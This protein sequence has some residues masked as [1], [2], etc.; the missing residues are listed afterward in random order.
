MQHDEAEADHLIF[1]P[2]AWASR[3]TR[4]RVRSGCKQEARLMKEIGAV[5]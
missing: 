4:C 1:L 3:E 5:G 2:Q